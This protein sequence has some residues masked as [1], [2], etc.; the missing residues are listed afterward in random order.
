MGSNTKN[1]IF[2]YLDTN[3]DGTGEKNAIGDYSGAG[4]T[5]FYYESTGYAEIHRMIISYEDG[6]GM[7]AE[8]YASLP[9]ALPVGIFVKQI[10]SDLSEML[11]L[12]DNEPITANAEWGELCYDIELKSYG[13]GNEFILARW[14]FGQSGSPLALDQGQKLVVVLNDDFTGLVSHRFMVQ[15]EIS[16]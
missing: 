11:D 8:R 13:P 6:P 9:A 4:L 3:G 7:R 10:D 2:H 15:G 12:T 14:T 1:K 5:W 16:R